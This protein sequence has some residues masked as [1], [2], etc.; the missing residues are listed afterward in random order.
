[1]AWS[2]LSS[3]D[4]IAE[5][6]SGPWRV[7]V[8]S[9]GERSKDDCRL[10]LVAETS[11]LRKET[12]LKRKS[13]NC[14]LYGAANVQASATKDYQDTYVFFEAARGGDGEHTGPIVEVF[15]LNKEGLKK[16]GEQELFEATY[17]RSEQTISSVTGR[18]LFSFCQVC[19]GPDLA[20]PE[21]NIF[22][23]VRVTVGCSGLCITPTLSKPKREAALKR[24]LER[25]AA[26]EREAKGS[27]AADYRKFAAGLEMQLRALLAR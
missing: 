7:V 4:I 24:F 26:N 17:H 27:V 10:Q 8:E 18:V 2:P 23:P 16:L 6:K 22:V 12:S 21:D 1:M 14:S 9:T 25:K 19:D 20:A 15:Q 5:A 3:A 13:V 11:Q